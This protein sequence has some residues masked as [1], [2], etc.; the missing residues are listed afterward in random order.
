MKRFIG[1]IKKEFLHIAR[2]KRTLF[3]L[4]GIPIV[5]I[6]L[7]GYAIT[8]EIRGAQIAIIDKSKDAATK[9]LTDKLLST[10]Y[11][12]VYSLLDSESEAEAAFKSGKIKLILVFEENFEQ[13]LSKYSLAHVRIIADATEPNTAN[14]LVF[15]T[16]SIIQDYVR[17]L[18]QSILATNK[19]SFS[20]MPEIRMRYNPEL[21][22]VYMFVPG[23]VAILLMLIS[24]MMTS[25]S[26]TREKELGSME[27]L[28]ASP[29]KPITVILAKVI[30]YLVL[31]SIITL[32]IL[33]LGFFVFKVPINGNLGFLLS[34]CLLFNLTA[35][36]L[37][38]LISSRTSSQQVALMV[39]LVGL[40]M[41]TILLSGFVF[42][43]E[44]MPVALQALAYMM[45][46]KWFIVIIKDI[47]LKGSDI[48]MLWR[49]TLVLVGYCL[50]FV[51]IST[52]N[53]KER[54][55]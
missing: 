46:A 26:I 21:K 7:F 31:S 29:M 20:V 44:N 2:D 25:I 43:V 24:A 4:I 33:A 18:N 30:P 10:G 3:I 5:Q 50:I 17:G 19:A 32:I 45:P 54:L 34:E 9:A 8:N 51:L 40:M 53:F 14:T 38:V 23:L 47:M 39:S 12:S 28:L 22:G 13:N 36:S 41:P 49:E 48:T 1:F 52:K 27:I 11:F 15:Y 35:L 37:G 55:Q 42:P 6:I 16:N